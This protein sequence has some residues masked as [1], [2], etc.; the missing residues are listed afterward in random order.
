V[1]LRIEVLRRRSG[2]YVFP[3]A[4]LVRC[5]RDRRARAASSGHARH[6]RTAAPGGART[7]LVDAWELAHRLAGAGRSHRRPR[8]KEGTLRRGVR[9]VCRRV[10]VID[11][12]RPMIVDS[13][14][15]TIRFGDDGCQVLPAPRRGGEPE[16][17]VGRFHRR[18]RQPIGTA[19]AGHLEYR[20]GRSERTTLRCSSTSSKTKAP[21]GRTHAKSCA[22]LRARAHQGTRDPVPPR[23]RDRFWKSPSRIRRSRS[24]SSLAPTKTWGRCSQ[25]GLRSCISHWLG[26][27]RIR[28]R[29]GAF[30]AFDR[31]SVLTKV[32]Q[33][34]R[35]RDAH[36]RAE[37]PLV[38]QQARGPVRAIAGREGLLKRYEPLLSRKLTSLRVR[39]H[40][41]YHLDQVL[42]RQRRGDIDFEGDRS[43]ALAERR[44][45]RTPLRDVAACA[46]LFIMQP[47]HHAATTPT[48]V[49][50]ADSRERACPGPFNG[51]RGF[52]GLHARVPRAHRGRVILAATSRR[53]HSCW[54]F[55]C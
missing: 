51:T 48:A 3:V 39:C 18:A 37:L 24:R 1:F 5:A 47:S 30:L 8:T 32:S 23:P 9:F 38:P 43:R 19:R 26:R 17:E 49:R 46:L 34:H 40:G 29:A 50:E 13:L 15:A 6:A 12:P 36:L 44:R 54:M 20:S 21:C 33:P 41:D 55:S 2:D 42:I 31:R 22:L 16:I 14:N 25:A 52:R 10:T 28:L 11:D 53:S 27:P 35:A 4:D 7:V 45:K